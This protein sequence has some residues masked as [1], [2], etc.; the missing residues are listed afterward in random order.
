MPSYPAIISTGAIIWYRSVPFLPIVPQNWFT[1]ANWP[2]STSEITHPLVLP[3]YNEVTRVPIML[4]KIAKQ[5]SEPVDTSIPTGVQ[6]RGSNYWWN[7]SANLRAERWGS[8]PIEGI[9]HRYQG[10]FEE[11]APKRFRGFSSGV[12]A[13]WCGQRTFIFE[14]LSPFLTQ[15]RRVYISRDERPSGAGF[16]PRKIILFWYWM[17]FSPA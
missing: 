17:T 4:D 5:A 16:L 15:S 11:S 3:W 7:T 2:S 12:G 1:V 6:T 8:T 13:R 10:F 14:F 9:L